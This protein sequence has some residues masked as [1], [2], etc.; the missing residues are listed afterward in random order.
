MQLHYRSSWYICRT[1]KISAW[2]GICKWEFNKCSFF[3]FLSFVIKHIFSPLL[4][5]F[6]SQ[7]AVCSSK[8][9][10]ILFGKQY[11]YFAHVLL[12]CITDSL[13]QEVPMDFVG[14]VRS[15]RAHL[16]SHIKIYSLFVKIKDTQANVSIHIF[17]TSSGR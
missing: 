11:R 9:W 7:R 3:F 14:K 1:I 12:L 13:T 4:N 5:I 10:Y 8:I 6:Y 16:W 17:W 2:A 15:C